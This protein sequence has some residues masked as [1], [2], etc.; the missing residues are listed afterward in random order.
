MW[1]AVDPPPQGG[2]GGGGQSPDV[3]VVE[4]NN[5][6][7]R[8]AAGT[9]EQE[10]NFKVEEPSPNYRLRKT[11]TAKVNAAKS[12]RIMIKTP[13]NSPKRQAEPSIHKT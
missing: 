13:N 3:I 10:T 1:N 11:E 9:S 4:S 5:N 6:G 2:K 12:K 8:G 7:S